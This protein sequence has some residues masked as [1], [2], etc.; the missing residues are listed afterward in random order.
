MA[1][2]KT[3]KRGRPAFRTDEEKKAL[4]RMYDQRAY[5]RLKADPVALQAKRNQQKQLKKEQAIHLY[6]SKKLHQLVCEQ[7]KK[8][9]VTPAAVIRNLIETHL[10]K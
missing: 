9:G 5:A 4:K 6:L 10:T 7:A 1:D 3:R 8:D 2:E